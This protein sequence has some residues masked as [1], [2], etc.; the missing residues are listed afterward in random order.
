[1]R[2]DDPTDV[3]ELRAAFRAAAGHRPDPDTPPVQLRLP[4][5]GP[6]LT[7]RTPTRRVPSHGTHAFG[8]TFAFDF[9]AVA[10]TGSRTASVVDWRTVLGTEPADR[11]LGHG[12]PVLAPAPG[13][14]TA[15]HDG[16]A[17]HE[18]RRSPLSLL[19]YGATQGR[20]LSRG[21]GAVAGNFVVLALEDRKAFVLLAHLQRGSVGVLP[22]AL[23]RA[24]DRVGA[25][26][27]SGN[28]TQPHL[29]MHAMD[30]A[31]L[32]S[33]RGLPIVFGDYRARPARRGGWHCRERGVPQWRE[34]VEPR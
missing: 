33:A 16:E 32:L 1:M 15:V 6:W 24:G 9:V 25:C 22:G 11:F 23:V 2:E 26:G 14:V 3:A 8:Q 20:R 34:V 31:S 10:D 17:D 21:I 30:S 28:S 7:V 27:N 4:F 12:R 19:V 13:R 18:A 5:R 29:H